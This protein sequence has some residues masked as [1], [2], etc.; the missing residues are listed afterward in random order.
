[1]VTESSKY[2]IRLSYCAASRSHSQQ[3]L[4]IGTRFSAIERIDGDKIGIDMAE[5]RTDEVEPARS[6]GRI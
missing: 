1:V 4:F 2:R 6:I 3:G 5:S